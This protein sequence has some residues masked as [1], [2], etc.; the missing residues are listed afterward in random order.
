MRNEEGRGR[1]EDAFFAV[2]GRVDHVLTHNRELCIVHIAYV[3]LL[4]NLDS[5][6]FGGGAEE[7]DDIIYD[8][9]L[10]LSLE[11]LHVNLVE[12]EHVQ[13]DATF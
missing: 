6:E 2:M 1:S 13:A 5:E 4:I 7:V 9:C 10:V 12:H 11:V 8:D 3:L